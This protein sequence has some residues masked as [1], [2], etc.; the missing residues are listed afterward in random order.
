MPIVRKIADLENFCNKLL[1]KRNWDRNIG[2][3]TLKYEI[4]MEFGY[5]EYIQKSTMKALIEFQFIKRDGMADR[6]KII[7]NMPKKDKNKEA[8]EEVD[9]LL[10][11][12][13]V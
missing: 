5:S 1:E 2:L 11:S 10:G 8:E 4:G 13:N 3:H 9:K 12:I 7:Y 6:F